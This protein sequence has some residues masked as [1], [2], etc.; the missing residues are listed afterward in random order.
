MVRNI[1][2]EYRAT[3][4]ATRLAGRAWY[5]DARE[6]AEL[7]AIETGHALETVIG[8][9]AALS[10]QQQWWQNVMLAR[11]TCT[12]GVMVQGHTT[13]NMRKVNEIL[14]GADPLDV[15]GGLKVRAFYA[16]M[17]SDGQDGGVTIDRHAWRTVCGRN[18]L[19]KRNA[20]PT[21]KAYTL[22]ADAFQQ[23]VRY[24]DEELTPA[25]LQAIVWIPRAA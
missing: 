9:I 23:A 6:T 8:V 22:A 17:L 20:V 25:E 3:D 7:I 4:A 14:Q 15:L 2:R 11:Q 21:D 12:A 19:G 18:E 1:L 13:D 10:P 5:R 16:N 24:C